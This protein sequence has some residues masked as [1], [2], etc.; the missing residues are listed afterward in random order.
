MH[1]SL[2]PVP[3]NWDDHDRTD[4]LPDHYG[5]NILPNAPLFSTLLRFAKR[6]P[7]RIAIRDINTST[8]RTHAELLVD[9]L[10]LRRQIQ[11]RL[12]PEILTRLQKGKEVY[13]AILAPGG[14]EYSVAFL[15]ILALGAA[16]VPL[17]KFQVSFHLCR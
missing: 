10:E 7:P 17:S 11:K 1:T 5:D 4:F 16:A 13:I 8:E 15:A 6:S 14:Y 3:D 12:S 2:E 9:V